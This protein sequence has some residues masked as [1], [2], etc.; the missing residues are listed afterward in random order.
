MSSHIM[1]IPFFN[2]TAPYP[3]LHAAHAGPR[4]LALHLHQVL[5]APS[6]G[7]NHRIAGNEPSGGAVR[8]EPS[9]T[10][11]RGGP[12]KWSGVHGS[13]VKEKG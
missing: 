10:Y 9:P 8:W 5:Q 3:P 7:W 6:S 11:F 1:K 12:R 2:F 4:G 13:G